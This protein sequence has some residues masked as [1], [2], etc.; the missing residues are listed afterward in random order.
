VGV[1]DVQESHRCDDV[2]GIA[3]GEKEC[4]RSESAAVPVHGGRVAGDLGLVDGELPLG[5]GHDSLCCGDGP[6]GLRQLLPGGGHLRLLLLQPR[7][8]LGGPLLQRIQRPAVEDRR[9]T[10]RLIARRGLRR[11]G[12]RRESGDRQHREGCPRH[13]HMGAPPGAREHQ[14]TS[15]C[16]GAATA[17]F[18]EMLS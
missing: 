3:T 6:L 7:L 18:G 9:S 8:H 10:A 14:S 12:R 16:A 15:A 11:L 5:V 17:P 13:R 4:Q 2:P 1:D